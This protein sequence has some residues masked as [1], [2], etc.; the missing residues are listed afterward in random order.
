MGSARQASQQ[1]LRAVVVSI[2]DGLILLRCAVNADTC[3]GTE[4]RHRT[5]GAILFPVFLALIIKQLVGA[6]VTQTFSFTVIKGRPKHRLAVEE[7]A[8]LDDK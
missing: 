3:W 5:T 4:L 2:I 6:T 1:K 7:Q 8:A